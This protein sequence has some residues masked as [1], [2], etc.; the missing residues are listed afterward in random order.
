[1]WFPVD[2][3]NEG[4]ITFMKVLPFRN[5]TML[6]QN[7]IIGVNDSF[8]DFILPLLIILGYTVLAFVVAILVFKNKMKEK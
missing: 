6:I 1:M 3:L 7:M 4:M 2:G 8:N 5:A